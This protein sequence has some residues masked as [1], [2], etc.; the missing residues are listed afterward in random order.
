MR[1]IF[2]VIALL[3]T[4]VTPARAFEPSEFIQWNQDRALRV[5]INYRYFFL[6]DQPVQVGKHGSEPALSQFDIQMQYRF[7]EDRRWGKLEGYLE[8]SLLTHED[9]YDRLNLAYGFAFTFLRNYR[10]EMGHER[11]LNIGTSNHDLGVS[12]FWVGGSYKILDKKDIILDVYGRYYLDSNIPSTIS[13]Q[14]K[15]EN[16][17]EAEGGARV[18]KRFNK[19]LE[20]TLAPYLLMGEDK[21]LS[22]IGAYPLF[23]YSIGKHFKVIP[24]GI[25]IEIGADI[26]RDIVGDKRDQ[27]NVWIK[28]RWQ[29]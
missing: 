28:L 25:G 15:N 11:K 12:L 23:T 10:I 1:T 22:R 9:I 20:F 7:F 2:L 17:L 19:F 24:E 26:S 29:F 4:C 6:N 16:N 18:T 27:Q 14:I 21:G 3:L 13:N 8:P 5:G